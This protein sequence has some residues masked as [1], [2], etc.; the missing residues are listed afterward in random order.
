MV[1]SVTIYCDAC[2]TTLQCS[3]LISHPLLRRGRGLYDPVH[4]SRRSADGTQTKLRK[5]TKT[6]GVRIVPP[7]RKRL[8]H[9]CCSGREGE[10]GFWSRFEVRSFVWSGSIG[11]IASHSDTAYVQ[12]DGDR[13][14]RR[15]TWF[16]EP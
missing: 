6:E 7:R 9:V 16:L 12:Y 4:R 10:F 8:G 1:S 3:T 15:R 14:R 2:H 5:G 13:D 11:R